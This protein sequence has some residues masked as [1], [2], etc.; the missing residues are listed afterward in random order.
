VPEG[1]VLLVAHGSR[2]PAGDAEFLAVADAYRAEHPELSVGVAHLE[3]AA[4]LLAAGLDTAARTAHHVV[5]V[6]VFLFAAGHVKV[7]VPL[8][9]A[10][11][12]RRNPGTTFVVAPWLGVHPAL[13]SIARDRARSALADSAEERKQEVLLVVGRGSSDPDANGDFAK[14]ARLV[15]EGSGLIHVETA[16]MGVTEPSVETSLARVAR[17]AP[18]R[19]VVLPYLLFGGRLVQRLASAVQAFERTHPWIAT[20]LAPHLGP[21]PR[22]LALLHERVQQA[23]TGRGTLP[24]DTCQYRVTLPGL[25]NQVGGLRALLYSMRHSLARSQATQPVHTHR[26]LKKHVLVCANADCVDRGGISVLETFRRAV[27]AVKRTRDIKVTR[28]S[29]MGRCGEG[30]TVAVYPD[31]VWY[32]RVT[33][34]DAVDIVHEHL[35]RDRLVGRLVGDVMH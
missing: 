19:V 29:C 20:S 31:G 14:V 23:A 32:R 17:L 7:D 2:D 34:A 8:A 16:Y 6:P 24:C 26:P 10:E 4:P 27:K 18:K 30:P 21:D 35:L 1:A 11:A 22:L 33:P 3:L 12:R 9:V 15:G 25:P 13:V 5:V 28:T